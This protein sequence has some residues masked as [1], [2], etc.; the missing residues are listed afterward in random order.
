V[1]ILSGFNAADN[2]SL[3]ATATC[4]LNARWPGNYADVYYGADGC[5]CD[6]SSNKIFSQY[7]GTPDPNSSGPT[8]NPYCAPAPPSPS[9][10]KGNDDGSSICDFI[11]AGTCK[12]AAQ[13]FQ[14]NVLYQQYTSP[15]WL[16]DSGA[17]IVNDIFPI[18]GHWARSF[19]VSITAARSSGNA[20]IPLRTIKE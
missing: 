3:K 7:Y 17:D 16:D 12:S 5:L 11:S 8:T 4:Q 10:T 18:A 13:R 20:T 19:S 9:Q 15:V 14:D 1:L 2:N 6:S